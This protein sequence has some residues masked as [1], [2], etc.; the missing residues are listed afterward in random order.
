MYVC[1]YS[2]SIY[3][4]TISTYVHYDI[5]N[6]REMKMLHKCTYICT[7]LLSVYICMLSVRIYAGMHLSGWTYVGG[8]LPPLEK[9]T[10]LRCVIYIVIIITD[11]TQVYRSLM[12]PKFWILWF[13]FPSAQLFSKRDII[14]YSDG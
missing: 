3:V 4:Q 10:T 8:H 12:P 5:T 11:L 9:I 14:H 6:T 2:C 1:M 13:C 7:Y